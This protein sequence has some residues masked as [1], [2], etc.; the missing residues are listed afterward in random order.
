MVN[1]FL[2]FFSFFFISLKLAL[3]KPQPTISE[4]AANDEQPSG[5]ETEAKELKSG[6]S[7]EAVGTIGS[8]RGMI[9]PFTALSMSFDSINYFVEM[10]SVDYSSLQSLGICS[11]DGFVG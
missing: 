6:S 10:P 11:T 5:E 9:L 7:T 3:G 4:E 1:S 2:I 8:K